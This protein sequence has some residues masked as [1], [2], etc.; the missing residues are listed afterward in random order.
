MPNLYKVQ[1]HERDLLRCSMAFHMMPWLGSTFFLVHTTL[2]S[3]QNL[4]FLFTFPI[5]QHKRL[6]HVA[7]KVFATRQ[8]IQTDGLTSS[9]NPITKARGAQVVMP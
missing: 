7:P 9:S 1:D 6:V 5:S 2:I 3:H 4:L 8:V